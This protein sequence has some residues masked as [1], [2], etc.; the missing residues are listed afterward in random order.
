[1]NRATRYEFSTGERFR[2]WRYP[3]TASLE[4]ER[5]SDGANLFF[6][7]GDD[8]NGLEAELESRYVDDVCGEYE[9]CLRFET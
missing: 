3:A 7:A 8:S 9:H 4:I 2:V 5:I 6:Q 1:M